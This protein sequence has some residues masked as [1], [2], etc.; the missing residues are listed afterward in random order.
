MIKKPIEFLEKLLLLHPAY[1]YAGLAAICFGLYC[2]SYLG[3]GDSKEAT[4]IEVSTS[5]PFEKSPEPVS[6]FTDLLATMEA[7]V[8]PQVNDLGDFA[9]SV[10]QLEKHITALVTD[11]STAS[12]QLVSG[13]FF[14]TGIDRAKFVA[15]Y[16]TSPVGVQRWRKSS[17][18]PKLEGDAALFEFVQSTLEPWLDTE[19][20]RISL[21]VY[22]SEINV[23]EVNASESTRPNL[24]AKL[25]VEVFGRKGAGQGIQAT[26][27]WKTNWIKAGKSE[28]LDSIE[29]LAQEEVAINVTGGQ[30]MLDYTESIFQHCDTLK[31][32]LGH[33]IDQWARRIPNIDLAGN[34]GI[35]VGDLNQDGMDDIYICQPHGLPNRMLIQNPDGTVDDVSQKAGLD[36]LDESRAALIIDL[37]NDGD[38]DLAVSTD[39]NLVLLSNKGDGTF[40][41]EHT[42]AIGRNSHSISAADFDQDGDLD[43]YLCKY[44]SINRQSDLLMFP[45]NVAS[46]EDGGRNVLLRNN[47]GWNFDDVTEQSGITTNNR[48][49]TRSAIWNDFDLDGDL[50]LYVT[51]EFATDQLFENDNGWFTD[52]AAEL[53]IDNAARHRSV[54]MG[55]FNQDGKLDLFVATDVPLASYRAVNRAKSA[56]LPSNQLS[57]FSTSLIGENQVWLTDSEKP[58]FRP[59]FLRAPVF[60]SES[61]FGSVA[62]D[63]NND[64]LDDVIVTN[65]YISRIG[66]DVDDLFYA[67]PLATERRKDDLG[68][69]FEAAMTNSIAVS[70]HQA[71]DLCREGY[72]LSSRQ[73]NRCYLSIGEMG[74]ANFSALSGVDLPDDARAVATT[75]WDGDG[76][77]DLV[78]SCRSAP[79]IR[80]LCNQINSINQS[81]HFDLKGTLSNRDA[82]GSRIELYLN[83][84]P[85]PLIKSL[86]AGSGNLSQSSK[87]L[88]FGVGQNRTIERAVVTWPNGHSQ[89]F[90]DISV[91]RRY[92]I[93]EGKSQAIE[94]NFDRFDLAIYSGASG[95]NSALPAVP[96]KSVF[97]PRAPLPKLQFKSDSDKWYALESVNDRPTLAVFWGRN[98]NSEQLIQRLSEESARISKRDLDCIAVMVDDASDDLKQQTQYASSVVER[99]GFPFRSGI[100]A[101]STIDKLRYLSGEWFGSQQL[102]RL[103]FAVLLDSNGNVAEYLSGLEL[104]TTQI[105]D[106]LALVEQPVWLYRQQA[107]P[108]GGRWTS[109]YRFAKLNRLRTRFREIGYDDDDQL[110]FGKSSGQRAHELCQKAIELKSVGEYDSSLGFYRQAIEMSPDYVPA[111]VGEGDLLRLLLKIRPELEPEVRLRMLA[112]AKSDFEY[113]LELEPANA[114]AIMGQANLSI[115]LKRVDEALAILMEYVKTDPT[116]YEIHAIIGR[117]LFQQDKAKEAATF[118]AKAFDNRPTLPFVAGDLGFLYL[119]A[120]EYRLANK[121]LRLANRLQPSDK[122]ILRLLAE[123]EFVSGQLDEAVRLFERVAEGDPNRRRSKNVLAWLLATCPYENQR[124][125][126]RAMQLI[127]PMVNLF[128]DS[129]PATLEIYAA[130]FAENGQFQQAMKFQQQAESMIDTDQTMEKYSKEQLIGLRNRLELYRRNRPYRMADLGQIPI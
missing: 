55:E 46:S 65:G 123:A 80:I 116:Q 77:A 15:K 71:A 58:A 36:I 4:A 9:A 128:G 114:A 121:F 53:G 107:A 61:A 56:L 59:F 94:K 47:E 109:N 54:S 60:S 98:S 38:Q 67:A 40:Q 76:D 30:L 99:T 1:F 62:T 41:L 17:T 93:I 103:P 122:N 112:T 125:G 19:D 64:G 26:A 104:N 43:L 96:E 113:A 16:A 42:L 127:D 11:K 68:Q 124:D 49:Y 92:S 85:K 39:E 24:E 97:Y 10:R 13:K 90:D 37:D 130:C 21:K 117:L 106:D 89:V 70:A 91:N 72:S 100:A 126:K 118:L 95:S 6:E 86:T 45:A 110:L 73:R 35:A 120:G 111:Y 31:T 69:R 57:K 22:A 25:V 88:M 108:L 27:I 33:G 75:D 3:S 82:I 32:Q 66:K 87:R 34:H 63:I 44:L 101:K 20:F 81:V 28:L 115:G 29:V 51:N 14:A 18:A 2:W 84:E 5:L 119:R 105:L 79:Q 48:N 74:F 129:S 7:S 50:D 12:E 83:G 52:V 8:E 102:P 23:S 78:I